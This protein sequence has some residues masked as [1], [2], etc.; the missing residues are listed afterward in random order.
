MA[1]TQAGYTRY[2][3]RGEIADGPAAGQY[4]WLAGNGNALSYWVKQTRDNIAREAKSAHIFRVCANVE[5]LTY[6]LADL[7]LLV[8]TLNA[9]ATPVA[10]SLVAAD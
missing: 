10:W 2:T 3:V 6:S 4:V 5:G 7:E 8:A 1:T 9:Q